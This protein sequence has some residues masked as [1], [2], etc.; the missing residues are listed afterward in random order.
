M[1]NIR[2]NKKNNKIISYRFAVCLER[3]AQGKQVRRY[4]TW[5]APEGL[6]PSKMRKAAERAADTWEQEIREAYQKEKE[7]GAAYT[8]PP[9]KRRDSFCDFVNNVWFPLQISNGSNKQT[10][11]TFYENMKKLIVAYFDGAILQ[12]I[13]PIQVQKFLIYLNWE[14]KTKRGKP[15]SR[16]TVRHYY[17]VLGMIFA[18]ADK[19]GMLVAN[20]ML[21]VD[22]PKKGKKPVDALTAEQAAYFLHA[23]TDE[24][25]DF[26]CMLQLLLT[27]GIRRG[28]CLGL[29]WK[30]IDERNAT[31][32][33][34]RSVVYTPKS[35]IIV[36][37]P[38]TADSIR[39]IPIMPKTL[40]LL[41]RLKQQTAAENKRTIL[42]DAFVFPGSRDIFHPRD[43]NAVTRRAKRF[44]KR[45]TLPDLSP[46]DL[47]HSCATLLLAQGADLKS[48][49]AIL[50]H[51]D[52]STTLNFYVK[53]DLRQMRSAT[54]KYAAA[55]NL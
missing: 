2:E 13:S 7:L 40:C 25:L 4:T 24:P 14:Y 49:Q 37:T 20:P 19:Q 43:P 54:E 45:N 9:E 39:T 53:S 30:D 31:M 15:L 28:E 33:V 23:L 38:K 34:S 3:D 27:S 8:L 5:K 26:R 1:A 36:S 55:L 42:K 46:H 10:T 47:R 41:Q 52:A 35:G 12:K 44:M 6:P 21:R 48:V 29:K 18:Y 50:G 22:A 17:D 51:A 11:V 16:Q 32:T